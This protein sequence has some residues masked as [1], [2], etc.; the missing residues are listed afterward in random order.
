MCI[1]L[2]CLRLR[3]LQSSHHLDN[4]CVAQYVAMPCSGA[5]CLSDSALFTHDV[6]ASPATTLMRPEAPRAVGTMLVVS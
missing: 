6:H 5:A 2:P 1:L 4:T 3:D